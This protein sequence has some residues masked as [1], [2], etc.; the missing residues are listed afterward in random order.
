MHLLRPDQI[1]ALRQL[2]RRA[3][4]VG[5][6]GPRQVGKT[7]LAR[8]LAATWVGPVTFFD[9]ERPSDLARLEEPELALEPLRGLVVLDEIQRRP[10]LFPIL[11]VLADR[12][13][14]PARFLVLG[15][16]S[17][18]LLRQE[19]ESLAG[20]I[21]F[22]ELG[23]LELSE[24]SARRLDRLWLRGGLPLSFLAPSDGQSLAW[25]RDFVRT[26][27]ERDLAGLGIGVPPP[28]LRR[29][30]TMLAHLHGQ[31]LSWSELGRSMGISDHTARRYADH[32]QSA[33]VV[34]LLQPWHENISKRQVKA[35]K[36]YVRDSGVLH[37][38]LD[39]GTREAL[40]VHPSGGASWEGLA[41][42]QILALLRPPPERCFFWATHQ[43]AELDLLVFDGARRLGFEVKR[44]AAPRLT[45][46]MRSAVETLRLDRLDV[47]HAGK[48]TFPL[49]A[50]VRAVAFSRL[51]ED[52]G[53]RRPP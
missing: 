29:F 38:L 24:V 37:A 5:L 53:A 52:L 44:T 21:A 50:K 47:I 33:L 19:S 49:A 23:G 36:L 8:D 28:T 51:L 42:S 12:P 40:E 15:S 14:K 18:E 13:R 48:E 1:D 27:L 30:W 34:Q 22:H 45:P 7:T 46:S 16:A 17:P 39:I 20:R 25:R 4:V 35:P 10:E 9:L 11:R 6:L 3:P 32:L 2:L 26:F 31:V 41:I 43:G